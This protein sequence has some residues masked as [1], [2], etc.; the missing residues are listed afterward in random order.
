MRKIPLRNGSSAPDSLADDV[1]LVDVEEFAVAGK[2]VGQEIGRGK[3]VVEIVLDVA[4]VEARVEIRL[5]VAVA[6]K[7]DV[8]AVRGAAVVDQRR[9]RSRRR[10]RQIATQR[11][12]Q[13]H[14]E[15]GN[16]V[17]GRI[18]RLRVAM[19]FRAKW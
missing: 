2:R 6:E 4:R 10:K 8:D 19:A 16:D 9:P 15:R 17:R 13:S 12:N 11:P 14:H 5:G 1:D 18:H 3:H 7:D